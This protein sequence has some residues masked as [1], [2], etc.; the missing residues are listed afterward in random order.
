MPG[1][2]VVEKLEQL[3]EEVLALGNLVEGVLIEAWDLLHNSDLDALEQLGEESRKVHKKRLAIEMGC[4]SLIAG[5][6][7]LDG[8]LR[9]LAAM[10]EIA[11]ELER[12]ADHGQRVAR[13]NFLTADP[14]LRKSLASL[15]RL[16]AQ[17]QSL[18]DSALT[19]FAQQDATAA[20]TVAAGTGE[21]EKL[22]QQVRRELLEV[23]KSKPR[24]ANQAIFLSR[25][26]YHLR[27]AAE[28]VAGICDWVVFAVE[29]SLGAS[30]LV[31]GTSAHLQDELSM[32]L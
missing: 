25:S 13:A 2:T 6:R 4:L 20:R 19:A 3:E 32:V 31:P 30:G 23:M 12:M 8:E 11:S 15:H 16:A 7:P 5:R 29:G 10:V 1:T 22:Y 21:V 26:A 18:L 17:V 9:S 28:R 14:Q 27:R 24:V